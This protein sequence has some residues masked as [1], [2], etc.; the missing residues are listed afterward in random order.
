LYSQRGDEFFIATGDVR[1]IALVG[2]LQLENDQWRRDAY[3]VISHSV[4][5]YRIDG[6][7]GFN[8]KTTIK[9]RV[10]LHESGNNGI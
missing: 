1:G 4:Y 9:N 2:R 6:A 5:A 7:L 10:W 3:C 8:G